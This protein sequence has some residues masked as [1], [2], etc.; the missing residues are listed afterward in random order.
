MWLALVLG[1]LPELLGLTCWS[2]VLFLVGCRFERWRAR[3]RSRS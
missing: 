1:N 2:V 3:R